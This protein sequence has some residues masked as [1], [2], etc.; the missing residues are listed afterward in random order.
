MTKSSLYL[1]VVIWDSHPLALGATPKQVYIDGIPQIDTPHVH[2]KPA[3]FQKVPQTPN[4]DHE[5]ADTVKYGGLPPLKP[6][7]SVKNVVFVNVQSVW[8]RVE[9]EEGIEQIFDVSTSE[10]TSGNGRTAVVVEDGKIQCIGSML[11]CAVGNLVGYE[12]IDLEGGSLAPGMTSF[13]A[14]LGLGEI[15]GESSTKDGQVFD[16]LS[17]SVPSIVGGDGAVIRAADGLQFATRD[18]L[19]VWSLLIKEDRCDVLCWQACVPIRG[20]CW[21]QCS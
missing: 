5:A 2:E 16:P 6:S 13:G 19:Y 11:T 10:R 7:R 15:A 18:A 9:N 3:A 4:F 1:D 8:S 17:G 21:N 20:D 12:M 14:P